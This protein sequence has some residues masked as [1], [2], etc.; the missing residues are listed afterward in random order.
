M[1]AWLSQAQEGI[2]LRHILSWGTNVGE[3]GD[4]NMFETVYSGNKTPRT[5]MDQLVPWCNLWRVPI[6]CRHLSKW[7][8]TN[9]ISIQRGN[10]QPVSI[11]HQPASLGSLQG[12][13][14]VSTLF[15]SVRV[16]THYAIPTTVQFLFKA[17][18]V[19]W[20][21]HDAYTFCNY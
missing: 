18:T 19:W 20:N 21:K 5:G 9:L 16:L 8:V 3:G 4:L 2:V 15:F 7:G 6:K 14:L 12:L 1:F 11:Y 13:L 10:W 17:C